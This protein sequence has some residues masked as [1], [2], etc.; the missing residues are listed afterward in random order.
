MKI[1]VNTELSI[2]KIDDEIFIYDRN[3][4]LIHAFNETG[5]IFW[6]AL[7]NEIPFQQL[8]N[9]ITEK[10]D[11]EPEDVANDLAVFLK[12]LKSLGIVE[13]DV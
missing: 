12:E 13:D 7:I 5:V 1:K 6:E 9:Q 3:K 4:S 8:S 2:R 10:Y 11:V